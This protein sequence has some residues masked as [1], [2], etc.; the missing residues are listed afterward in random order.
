MLSKRYVWCARARPCRPAPGRTA[1]T[2]TSQTAAAKVIPVTAPLLLIL[3]PVEVVGRDGAVRLGGPKE[4]C[5]LA[6]LAVH[7]GRVVAEDLLVDAL[8]RTALARWTSPSTEELHEFSVP[9]WW[10]VD[11]PEEPV[12]RLTPGSWSRRCLAHVGAVSVPGR[13][14]N[15]T[16]T[17]PD[18]RKRVGLGW[19]DGSRD[20]ESAQG[21]SR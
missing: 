15:V 20:A 2:W 6:M 12:G 14:N 3:G 21:S 19:W 7:A 13:W 16:E 11:L 18:P 4:R 17:D 8:G 5:L 10:R 9:R 1:G